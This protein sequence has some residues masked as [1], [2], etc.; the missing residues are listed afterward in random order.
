MQATSAKSR[1]TGRQQPCA[2]EV[3]KEVDGSSCQAARCKESAS[4]VK[5]DDEEASPGEEENFD[6]IWKELSE[7]QGGMEP[8]DCHCCSSG[9]R[10]RRS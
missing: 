5:I 9:V 2:T 10:A 6:K 3:G 4:R 8:A 1:Q 7:A